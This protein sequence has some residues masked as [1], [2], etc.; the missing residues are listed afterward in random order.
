MSYAKEVS[1]MAEPK[2]HAEKIEMVSYIFIYLKS[3]KKVRL[4]FFISS[5]DSWWLQQAA[6]HPELLEQITH[7]RKE[8]NTHH[9]PPGEDGHDVIHADGGVPHTKMVHKVIQTG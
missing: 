1:S 9:E 2:S 3:C 6:S 5:N 7:W 4:W 8:G